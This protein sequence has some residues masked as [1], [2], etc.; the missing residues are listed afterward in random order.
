MYVVIKGLSYDEVYDY[1]ADAFAH[2]DD[3]EDDIHIDDYGYVDADA[4]DMRRH[5]EIDAGVGSD[6]EDYF[7]DVIEDLAYDEPDAEIDFL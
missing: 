3:W 5:V 1:I 2:L 4:G 7:V 6:L